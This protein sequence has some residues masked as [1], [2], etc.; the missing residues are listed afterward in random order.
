MAKAGTRTAARRKPASRNGGGT[1]F[2]DAYIQAVTKDFRAHGLRAI[3]AV[4][5]EDPV[6]YMKLCASI[7]S[8]S[9]AAEP[10][11]LE[12]LSDDQLIEHARDLAAALGVAAHS[13]PEGS[14]KPEE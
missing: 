6:T 1:A 2:D 5:E 12:S 9:A 4:R 7:L 11:P 8:K 3:T 14:S 13:H 10:D